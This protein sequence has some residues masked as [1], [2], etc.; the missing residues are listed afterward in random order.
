MNLNWREDP[1]F[2]SDY[3]L[4]DGN[5]ATSIVF[6]SSGS[7]YIEHGSYVSD[8]EIAIDADSADFSP[9]A[10]IGLWESQTGLSLSVELEP[11]EAF[12]LD[13]T[14]SP[15]EANKRAKE[16]IRR[17][18]Q[19]LGEDESEPKI[20]VLPLI[21]AGAFLVA[22]SWFV[23]ST[24]IKPSETEYN[25]A[26]SVSDFEPILARYVVP[27]NVSDL[28]AEVLALT[29]QVPDV[30]ASAEGKASEAS[31]TKVNE[32]SDRCES[33]LSVPFLSEQELTS[34]KNDLAGSID[35]VEEE[36]YDFDNKPEPEPTPAQTPTPTS[37]PVVSPPTTPTKP[38]AA[39]PTP[40]APKPSTP[41]V[42]PT[43]TPKPPA[44]EPTPTPVPQP[45]ATF[46]LTCK[47]VHT[48]IITAASG[49]V[50]VNGLSKKTVQFTSDVDSTYSGTYTGSEI[51]YR[52]VGGS[53]SWN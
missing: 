51:N 23:I 7:G 38:P 44:P 13:F 39:K 14:T 18:R 9:D 15:R 37:P 1:F 2:E 6:S 17:V 50:N 34:C 32:N 42:A 19:E 47:G 49:V 11:E 25:L 12:E 36:V 16:E 27:Q 46:S 41:T 33:A 22:G 43:P 40:T 5:V 4:F 26:Y 29:K 30:L 53:C 35:Q 8:S 21:L 10:L 28:S 45:P 3:R 52:T 31:I 20:R 24:N 48:V